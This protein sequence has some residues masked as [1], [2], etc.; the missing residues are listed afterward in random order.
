MKK[1]LIV[2]LIVLVMCTPIMLAGCQDK[3]EYE[4]MKSTFAFGTD[5]Q[6]YSPTFELIVGETVYMALEVK[7]NAYNEKGKQTEKEEVQCSLTIPKITAI[8][9]YYVSGQTI[10]GVPD[11]LT[12]N[13]TYT[14]TIGT[15]STKT[16]G[17]RFIFKFVPTAAGSVRMDL[18][19]SDPVPQRYN[20]FKIVDFVEE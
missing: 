17:E 15:N 16:E 11:V 6:H 1:I 5:G 10:T 12:G 14:F 2:L 7:I 13:V 8:D 20:T 4:V 19:F 3:L 18:V 9:A